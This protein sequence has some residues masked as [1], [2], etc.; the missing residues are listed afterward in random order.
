MRS[1]KYGTVKLYDD[2]IREM[3]M[4][5]IS[6]CQIG[7]QL[8]FSNGKI[9]ARAK[10]LGL[11]FSG[12][13]KA[14]PIGDRLELKKEQII[15]LYKN[16]IGIK[17][18]A[19]QVNDNYNAVRKFLQENKFNSNNKKKKIIIIPVVSDFTKWAAENNIINAKV[20][21]LLDNNIRH[22][23]YLQS[24][25][26]AGDNS[27]FLFEDEW[28]FRQEQV[29]GFLLA[30]TGKFD[31][32]VYGRK[33]SISIVEKKVA[34][35]FISENHIQPTKTGGIINFGL[36]Y[37]ND[38]IG[39]LQLRHHHRKSGEIVISRIC[40]KRGV[41]I[42][43][44]FSKLIKHSMKWCKENNHPKL[45]TWSDNR[46]TTGE[47]Y[48][49]AGFILDQE[50]PADYSYVQLDNAIDRRSKQSMKKSNINC[51][52]G[53]TEREYTLQLGYERIWDCGKKRFVCGV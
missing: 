11:D 53:L 5:G 8:G 40:F 21:S 20:F 37:Q 31:Q 39:L 10:I 12:K 42:I 47:S 6:S 4:A 13:F 7:K 43:G 19:A 25:R 51:P 41:Q 23:K 26:E 52:V 1:E 35:T 46:W 32:Q 48:I 22:K 30:K 17:R 15:K 28:N 45:I 18:I 36:C 9:L 24:L 34:T 29:K 44:G 38:I 33:C 50:L 27:I 14:T 16:G 2:Q 49:K 3:H